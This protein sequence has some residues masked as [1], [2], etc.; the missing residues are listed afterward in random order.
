MRYF[1]LL[2]L[3]AVACNTTQERLPEGKTDVTPHPEF[4]KIRPTAIAVLK[5]DAPTRDLR[6]MLRPAMYEGLFRRNYSCLKLQSVD[7]ASHNGDTVDNRE[8][9]YDATFKVTVD[10]WKSVHGGV[11]YVASG[12][13][14][15][16]HRQG[17]VL[18]TI[19]FTNEVFDA[20]VEAGA[21][22]D[23]D[24]IRALAERIA[25]KVPKRPEP[26]SE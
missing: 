26:A 17:E 2:S 20:H 19:A 6:E 24:A 12:K 3:L 9:P 1:V 21:S 25:A 16:R 8:L 10:E 13:A 11:Y 22:D 7:K 14:V 18:F 5:V 23:T 15:M 4:D